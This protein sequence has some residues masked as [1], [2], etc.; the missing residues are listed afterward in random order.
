MS[1]R[2][3]KRFS[4][5]VFIT[6]LLFITGIQTFCQESLLNREINLNRSTGQISTLLKELSRKGKFSFTYTSEIHP[7]RMASVLNHRQALRSHL[8]DIFRY[9]SITFL[10]QNRKILLI[11]LKKETTEKR[12]H[13]KLVKGIVVDSR[14]RRPLPYSNIFLY[15]KSIGTIS[16]LAGRFTVKIPPEYESDTL[17]ISHIGYEVTGIPVSV[18]DT[19]DIVI[20]L[21]ADKVQIREIVVKPL[22]PIYIITKAVENIRHNYDDKP[23]LYTGFFRESTQ[24]DNKNI[25]LSEAILNV[26]KEPYT[27]FR[28]DQIKIFK[29]RKGTNTN[30][31]EYVEF[32]VQGGLYNTLQLDIVK[33]L[34][35]FLD[36]DYF[37]LYNYR[38]ERTIMHFNRL[39]YVIAFKQQEGVKYPCYSG[40]VYIDVETL[41]I[42]GATFE[43]PETGMTYAA[44]I[45]VQKTPRR[46]G[47]KPLS[48]TYHV[49][50]RYYNNRWNLS[51]IRS[52]ILVK[53]RR[54][55]NKQQDRF[56][57]VFTSVSEFVITNK[58]TL[59][60]VR[61]KTNE[62][63]RPRDILEK[64]IGETDIEFWG[65][66]NIITPEE[67][68]ERTIL[69]LGRRHNILS[70]KEIRAIKIE[71]EKEQKQEQEQEQQDEEPEGTR[72][73][74][75]S[76]NQNEIYNGNSD[77]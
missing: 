59:N 4:F 19:T 55:K 29:G 37:A 36:A 16:N 49:F 56:N 21:S 68:V 73:K 6:I 31:K 48:A 47:V 15:N 69:R 20:R 26:Y 41:A 10:E 40:K 43:M 45:Y 77:E 11:P 39:T 2:E 3:T 51:N 61:F 76:V 28:D 12:E 24:Q 18:I 70:E 14:N 27:S 63:S 42:V 52:H 35:S 72:Y 33:N 34:P 66:E 44:G 60:V 1:S 8:E 17:Q 25:S 64:Q 65:D 71:E 57:S 62:I 22:D 54:K 38:V 74:N 5:P 32:I 9:D 67:P 53:V 46:T 30:E 58:D 23:A 50:Y 75:D 7:E 13:F